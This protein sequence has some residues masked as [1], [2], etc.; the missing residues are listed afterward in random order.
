MRNLKAL[1]KFSLIFVLAANLFFACSSGDDGGNESAE[2]KTSENSESPTNPN[3][4]ENSSSGT[5]ET[6]D[7]DS[8][9]ESELPDLTKSD[10]FAGQ[11]YI[12]NDGEGL[13]FN[14]DGTVISKLLSGRSGSGTDG[15]YS[16]QQWQK[17]T[18]H[19]YSPKFDFYPATKRI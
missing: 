12:N 14:N 6:K 5:T 11:A 9:G 16:L 3:T 8:Y 15:S 17:D 7:P 18:L 2:T 13:F 10:S 1:W 4:P 19:S